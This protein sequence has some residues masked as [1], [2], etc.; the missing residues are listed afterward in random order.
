MILILSITLLCV[1]IAL[2]VHKNWKKRSLNLPPSPISIP[3]IGHLHLWTDPKKMVETAMMYSK[4]LGG[5]FSMNFG[6]KTMVFIADPD[7]IKEAATKHR[8]LLSDR[9]VN[10]F[11]ALRMIYSTD[12]KGACVMSDHNDYHSNYR[13][14]FKK[15]FVSGEGMKTMMPIIN[16]EITE[17]LN[18][19]RESSESGEV[20]SAS[21]VSYRLTFNMISKTLFNT[22]AY[23]HED[24]DIADIFEIT[25]QIVEESLVPFLQDLFP[26]CSILDQKRENK[27]KKTIEERDRLYRK[28]IRQAR[29]THVKGGKRHWLDI[30]FN[31]M[32]EIT[33]DQLVALL[34]DII[35]AGFDT[36]AHGLQTAVT[37]LAKYP[38]IQSEL[39]QALKGMHI[40]S[41]D[42]K[43]LQAIPYL[44]NFI[45]EVFRFKPIS[46]MLVP[47]KARDN[48]NMAGY[49]I[50]K[51][52]VVYLVHHSECYNDKWNNPS[53]FNPKRWEDPAC[54]INP[55]GQGIRRCP[56]ERIGKTLLYTA[57]ASYV[58]YFTWTE[59]ETPNSTAF[60]FSSIHKFATE[61]KFYVS[62]VDT[63]T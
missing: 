51:G 19:L 59:T 2:T 9:P 7:L 15:E 56:G 33:E 12:M 16:Y 48:V 45:Q 34:V 5:I 62:K 55:F 31:T 57:V 3:L 29:D 41:M 46:P 60:E 39:R 26:G 21:D 50:P 17:A 40:P 11:L 4:T 32:P 47:H 25:H 36:T 58:R 42:L 10:D 44:K 37:M 30:I 54:N 6:A 1:F 20:V 61:P 53:E 24:K 28:V 23:K 38:K 43:D 63:T 14:L 49:T 8:Q 22:R 27:F 13:T 35:A 18:N 52:A